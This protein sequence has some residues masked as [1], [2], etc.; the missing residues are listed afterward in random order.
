MSKTVKERASNVVHRERNY[1]EVSALRKQLRTIFLHRILHKWVG[2]G[3]E[4]K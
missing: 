1:Y 3:E 2:G 4:K